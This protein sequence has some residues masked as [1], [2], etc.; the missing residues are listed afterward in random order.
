M[1]MRCVRS[2]RTLFLMT[3]SNMSP[4]A[5]NSITI[6]RCVGVRKTCRGQQRVSNER[7]SPVS[8]LQT[9]QEV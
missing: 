9:A 5:A 4:P 2:V 3:Y 7:A 8:L 6:A 1:H